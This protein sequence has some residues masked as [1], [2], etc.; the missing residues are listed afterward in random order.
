MG[1]QSRR[2]NYRSRRERYE[3]HKR[4]FKVI[5]IFSVI[6]LGVWIFKERYEIWAWLKTYFY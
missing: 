1:Y 5:L 6:A 4:N 2:R 3:K